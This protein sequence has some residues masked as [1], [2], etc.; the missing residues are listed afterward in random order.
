MKTALFCPSL[1]LTFTA[2]ALA[3]DPQPPNVI[4]I[5]ADQL[6]YESTG[7]GGGPRASR[8]MLST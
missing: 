6:R 4:V 8:P 2:S 1:L 7:Y 5:V 3:G